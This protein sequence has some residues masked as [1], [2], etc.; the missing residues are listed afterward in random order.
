MKQFLG[1]LRLVLFLSISEGNYRLYHS[2]YH[3]LNNDHDCFYRFENSFNDLAR[4]LVPYCIRHTSIYS[5]ETCFGTKYT[6]HELHSINVTPQQLFE[7]FAPIDL[8]DDYAAYLL[9]KSSNGNSEHVYCNCSDRL[10]FGTQCQY[11][12]T[13]GH[14]TSLFDEIVSLTAM[15]SKPDEN[16]LYWM[17]EQRSTTCYMDFNCTTYTG[18][19][20]DWREIGDG[21]VHCTNGIDEKNFVTMELSDCDAETEYR[22]RNGLCIP[23]I[24]LLDRT[25][26]CP[27]WYDEQN[28]SKNKST[29]LHELC[30]SKTKT[31]K[32]E[33][34]KLGL[35]FFSCSDGQRV[36]TRFGGGYS[37]SNLRN[38]FMLKTLF[39]PY[40]NSSLNDPCYLTIMCLFNVLCLFQP[41]PNGIEQHCEELLSTNE[42]TSLCSKMFFFPP[43]PFIFPFVRLLYMPRKLWDTIFPDF[44]CWN[45]S[46]CNIYSHFSVFPYFGFDCVSAEEFFF[47]YM[48]YEYEFGFDLPTRLLLIIQSLFSHCTHQ[49]THPN[50]YTCSSTLSIS[51]YRVLDVKFH[52]CFPWL[53]MREDESSTST[54]AMSACHLP[55]RFTCGENQCIPRQ[56][57]HDG[58]DDCWSGVDELFLIGCT[59]EFDCQYLREL[60]ISRTY[61]FIYQDVCDGNDIFK[62]S[63]G[64]R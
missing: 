29:Y 46:I 50:L 54:N 15:A 33:E 59:D 10:S 56:L 2:H 9:T 36:T 38:V 39:R 12:F 48:I 25:F 31:A 52:D 51:F 1:L 63:I 45:G 58:F 61:F 19:C 17:D 40:I 57:L 60:N 43:G 62:S 55:D 49:D 42:T 32:C 7:W 13:V 37:C 35:N 34:F 4:H 21:F 41:C 5:K 64:Y 22:C 28:S 23:R 8:I 14:E 24:F 44:V 26:D 47:H 3:L 18:F 27:D 16:D 20:L 11:R 30:P 53:M 6:F